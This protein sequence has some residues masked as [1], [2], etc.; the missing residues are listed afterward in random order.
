LAGVMARL[1]GPLEP[2]EEVDEELLEPPSA[3]V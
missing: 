3:G 1:T 2:D